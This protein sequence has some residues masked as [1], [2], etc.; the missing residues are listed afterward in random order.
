MKKMFFLFAVVTGMSLI[1]V[2][3]S[4]QQTQNHPVAMSHKKPVNISLPVNFSLGEKA[5]A[6]GCYG[7]NYDECRA[8]GFNKFESFELAVMICAGLA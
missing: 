6:Q 5:Y 1:S 7:K 2:Q 4:L 8:L 3:F